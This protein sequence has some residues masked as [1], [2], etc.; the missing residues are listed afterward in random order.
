MFVVVL[1]CKIPCLF[2]L[3]FCH[4]NIVSRPRRNA[5]SQ[6]GVFL[7]FVCAFSWAPH[8]CFFGMFSCHCSQMKC[9]PGLSKS[10]CT[11]K[12]RTVKSFPVNSLTISPCLHGNRTVLVFVDDCP[13]PGCIRGSLFWNLYLSAK[14]S[15]GMLKTRIWIAKRNFFLNRRVSSVER[16]LDVKGSKW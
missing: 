2:V 6:V 14:F 8:K 11:L 4:Q 7:L 15:D 13:A 3:Y 1:L 12:I 5:C 9:V 10:Q 16:G